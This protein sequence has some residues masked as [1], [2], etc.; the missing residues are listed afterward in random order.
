MK[1][2]FPEYHFTIREEDHVKTIF[3]ELRGKY[4][5]LTPEE[6]VRQHLIRYLIEE[7]KYPKSLIGVEFPVPVGSMMQRADVVIYHTDGKPILLA[8]CKAPEVGINQKV[9][10][11]ISVYNLQLNVPY[12]IL[13][14]GMKHYCC[15]MDFENKKFIFLE[16]IPDYTDIIPFGN[17]K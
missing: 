15:K 11:Q 14:N 4:V 10:D 6:W 1:L 12:L 13:T 5:A 2:N 7:K 16:S 3:D 17:I 9:F 8:E